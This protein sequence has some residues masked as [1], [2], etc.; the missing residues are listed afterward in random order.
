MKFDLIISN[1]P[2][3]SS[4][5]IKILRDI[6]KISDEVIFVHPSTWLLDRKMKKKLFNDIRTD[7][8]HKLKDV[9]MFNGNKIFD[10]ELFVPTVI[11]HIDMN[12]SGNCN[13]NYFGNEFTISDIYDI[14][15]FGNDWKSIILPFIDKIKTDNNVWANKVS[16][17]NIDDDKY[18]VQLAGIRGDIFRKFSTD[19]KKIKDDFY[20][21][22]M[23][24]SGENKESIWDLFKDNNTSNFTT[25]HSKYC[26][27][28]PMGRG[29][30]VKNDK[31]KMVNDDFYTIFSNAETEVIEK[32]WN[33]EKY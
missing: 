29:N 27:Q 6:I 10:I 28:I 19:S 16:K 9:E 21:I 1:P 2:Y 25:N 33:N 7:I 32:N 31:T 5:D 23:K 17:E 11:T 8:N 3:N 14:T 13:V 30:I 4:L 18:Y 22:V 15:K 20:T 12:H 24:D 26:F